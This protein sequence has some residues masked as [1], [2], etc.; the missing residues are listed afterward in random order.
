M[1]RVFQES[2]VT[3][4]PAKIVVVFIFL[5][6]KSGNSMACWRRKLPVPED[7]RA[8]YYEEIEDVLD[9]LDEKR[10]V[11][12]DECVPVLFWRYGM[13]ANVWCLP[14]RLPPKASDRALPQE[15]KKKRGFWRRLF[16]L[17]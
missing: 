12:V 14:P 15:K 11:F 9:Q 6:S 2:V 10:Q 7:V 16:G 3:Y 1:D 17:K 13:P 4:N 8:R 5:L